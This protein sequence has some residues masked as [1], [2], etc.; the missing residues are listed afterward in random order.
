MAGVRQGIST[1]TSKTRWISI[2][3]VGPGDWTSNNALNVAVQAAIERHR[4]K[5]WRAQADERHTFIRLDSFSDKA[6]V[7]MYHILMT[8]RQP[9]EPQSCSMLSALSG[10]HQLVWSVASECS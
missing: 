4:E 7:S 10:S 5:L 1:E 8:G 3:T 2:G 9:D 6:L